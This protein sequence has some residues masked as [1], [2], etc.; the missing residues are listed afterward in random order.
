MRGASTDSEMCNGLL[1][2]T[3]SG[4]SMRFGMLI[5]IEAVCSFQ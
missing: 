3:E 2:L 5:P 4:V 1:I